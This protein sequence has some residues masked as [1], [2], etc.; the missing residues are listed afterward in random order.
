[1]THLVASYSQINTH[2]DQGFAKAKKVVF[3][4]IFSQLMFMSGAITQPEVLAP[5]PEMNRRL[6]SEALEKMKSGLDKQ[7]TDQKIQNDK[8]KSA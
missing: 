3:M 5:Q 4:K 8:S 6:E 7:I 1:M 2:F